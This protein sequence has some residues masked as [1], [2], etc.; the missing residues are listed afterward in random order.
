[1]PVLCSVAN[2]QILPSATVPY[3]FAPLRSRLLLWLIR[4]MKF[5]SGNDACPS[6]PARMKCSVD[7]YT[8]T[9]G[10]S[11][12]VPRRSRYTEE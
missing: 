3:D 1:M 6:P 9:R 7:S 10:F 12:E 4:S 8:V 2:V 11:A 5:L